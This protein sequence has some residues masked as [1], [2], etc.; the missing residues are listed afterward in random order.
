M[1][2]LP[3]KLATLS[4]S[5]PNFVQKTWRKTKQRCSKRYNDAWVLSA[6]AEAVGA[7]LKKRLRAPVVRRSLGR[8]E[9]DKHNRE[10]KTRDMGALLAPTHPAIALHWYLL[11]DGRN[12]AQMDIYALGY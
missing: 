7:A 3:T 6:A 4:A 11:T 9:K 10:E 2:F 12:V 1:S 5:I 8:G